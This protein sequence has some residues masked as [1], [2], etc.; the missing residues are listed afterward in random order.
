MATELKDTLQRICSTNELFALFDFWTTQRQ[1]KVF[2]YL[3]Q[4]DPKLY[5]D[6]DANRRSI[7]VRATGIISPPCSLRGI[8][9]AYLLVPRQPVVFRLNGKRGR[10][11][12]F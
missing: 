7:L 6:L 4:K 11:W 1:N 12:N 5:S 9:S 10:L 8:V 3:K 2:Q